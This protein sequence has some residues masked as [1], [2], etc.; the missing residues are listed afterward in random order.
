MVN[1]FDDAAIGEFHHIPAISG[2]YLGDHR[3][4]FDMRMFEGNKTKNWMW[5]AHRAGDWMFGVADYFVGY[6]EC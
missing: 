6:V 3:L 5:T 4:E 1:V 2:F